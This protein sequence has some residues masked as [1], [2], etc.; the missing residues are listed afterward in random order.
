M[1]KTLELLEKNKD[2][3]K[4]YEKL[5]RHLA[6]KIEVKLTNDD[7]EVDIFEFYPA[8]YDIYSRFM[9][10]APMID[11]AEEGAVS[12][13]FAEK[14][15]EV[16][17]DIVK[18]SY[19]DW[20]DEICKQFV[21]NNMESMMGIIEKIMPETPKDTKRLKKFQKQLGHLQAKAGVEP[22]QQEPSNDSDDS[23]SNPEAE[24]TSPE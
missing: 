24:G 4:D 3:I 7:G 12:G 2:T 22:T 20:P 10:I 17:V 13:E 5:K 19:P 8:T 15:L 18:E 11:D 14:L 1:N 16:F 23:E 6:K 21:G 9:T